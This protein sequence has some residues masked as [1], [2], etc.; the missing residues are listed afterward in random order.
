MGRKD[1]KSREEDLVVQKLDN[2]VLIYDLRANRAFCL[3]ETSAA[4]W[5]ACDGNR[6]HGAIAAFVS[7]RLGTQAS[8]DLV[9]LALDQ[10]K[11]ESLITPESPVEPRYAGL[12]RR[13]VIRKIGIGSMVAL[14]VVA[15]MVAPTA[16]QAQ[17]CLA[18]GSS[19]GTAT[20]AGNCPSSSQAQ[21][22]AACNT[23]TGSVC[24][25][26]SATATASCNGNPSVFP[27]VCA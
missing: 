18:A 3:N 26:G 16:I 17:T 6:D 4:V 24:C 25:S 22:N 19:S 21:K 14:P 2:E 10:L 23:Q 12:S 7:E 1:P 11:K 27:C 9:W 13:E 8:D 20:L 15:A 5:E